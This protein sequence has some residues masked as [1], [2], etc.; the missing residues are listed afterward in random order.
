VGRED[1][2]GPHVVTFPDEAAY[3]AYRADARLAALAHLRTASVVHTEVLAGEDGPRYPTWPRR[4][5]GQA[6]RLPAEGHRIGER[7]DLDG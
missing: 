4:A 1:V 5:R 2:G 7:A 6:P 3:H